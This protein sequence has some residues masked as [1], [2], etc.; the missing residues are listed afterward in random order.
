M[1]H[2]ARALVGGA[3]PRSAKEHVVLALLNAQWRGGS[4]LAEQL[5][6]TTTIQEPFLLDEPARAKW[7]EHDAASATY[8][9][10]RCAFHQYNHS[11]LLAWQHW[12][13]EF[14]KMRRLLNFGAFGELQRRCRTAGGAGGHVR[15]VKAIRMVGDLHKVARECESRRRE[16][17]YSCVFIQLVRHP[18][19]TLRSEVASAGVPRVAAWKKTSSSRINR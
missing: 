11:A 13:G 15:A 12:R 8:N 17:N 10:L 6:F 14:A 19:A 2:D 16:G 3:A 4:T 1:K 7:V 18:L 9:A 5:L